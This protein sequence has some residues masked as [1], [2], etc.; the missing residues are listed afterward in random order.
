MAKQVITVLTDD[1][2]GSVADR[3]VEFGLDGVNYT[4]D[5]SDKNVGALR[6]ALDPYLKAAVRL[7][8]NGTES[9]PASRARR[10]AER[11]SGREQNQK[12]RE[13]ATRHRHTV[14]GRGRIPQTVVDAYNATH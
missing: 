9:R 13:W 10:S 12:I 7:G 5:L 14:A 2:D 3:T 1:L 8:R 6:A 11:L 4:I